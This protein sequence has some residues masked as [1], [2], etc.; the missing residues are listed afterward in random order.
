MAL[1]DAKTE[2]EMTGEPKICTYRFCTASVLETYSVAGGTAGTGSAD[3]RQHA[4]RTP[5][6]Y[7]RVLYGFRTD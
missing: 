1:T 7:V 2:I 4:P 6:L 3:H 5:D